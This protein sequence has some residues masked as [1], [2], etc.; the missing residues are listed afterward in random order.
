MVGSETTGLRGDPIVL[1]DIDSGKIITEIIFISI[2]PVIGV[3][4]IVSTKNGWNWL[5]EPKAEWLF[6]RILDKKSEAA[7]YYLVGIL[8]IIMGTILIIQ[9]LLVLGGVVPASEVTVTTLKQSPPLSATP[10][11]LDILHRNIAIYLNILLASL[12]SLIAIRRKRIGKG[13]P[14]RWLRKMFENDKIVLAL[15]FIFGMIALYST[16]MMT[17]SIKELGRSLGYW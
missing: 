9:R 7:G 12:A 3:L 16:V 4:L 14:P 8:F 11:H 2:F 5:L 13:E 1:S 15:Y 17:P 6:W 10:P